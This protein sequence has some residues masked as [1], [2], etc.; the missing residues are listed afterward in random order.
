MD[1]HAITL[2]NPF[3]ELLLPVLATLGLVGSAGAIARRV[4]L[5]PSIV[6][7]LVIRKL[8]WPPGFPGLLM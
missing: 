3:E 2:D 1:S 5:P 8:R 7:V 4:I 6:V